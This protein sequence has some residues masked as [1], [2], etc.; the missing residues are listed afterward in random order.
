MSV[1]SSLSVGFFQR[2]GGAPRLAGSAFAS[3]VQHPEGNNPPLSTNADERSELARRLA[4]GQFT[5]TAELVPPVSTD[6]ADL[7]V[8]ALPLRGLATAVN[9]TDGAGAKA[10]LSSLVAAHI[11]RQNGIEPIMQMTCRDRNRLALQND[12]LGALALGVRNVLIISGDD[13]RTGDQPSTKP[14]FDLDSKGLLAVAQQIADERRLPSG[15]TVR[16]PTQLVL[17]AA[18]LP[19][20]PPDGWFPADLIAKADAGARFVQTQ[21]CM[22]IAIARR[23][24]AR[25]H[26]LG[27]TNR[28]KLLIGVSPIPSARSAR[29]MRTRLFGTIIPDSIVERLDRAGDP[30]REG[31]QI[32]VEIMHELAAIPGVAGAH[33]MAPQNPSAIAEVIAAFD[34][35]NLN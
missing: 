31:V 15:T 22:D 32:C 20:D 5:I 9:I 18:A 29:W 34:A 10:H 25:L 2:R 4:D 30:R 6:P 8:R 12:L 11:L 24:I 19:V 35:A 21:F 16:G 14:V 3:V 7:L 28:L 23:W 26:D 27:L 17:G 33:I 13:P 1:R